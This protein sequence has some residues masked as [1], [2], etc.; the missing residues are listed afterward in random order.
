MCGSIEIKDQ[1]HVNK[2]VVQAVKNYCLI[3]ELFATLQIIHT[4]GRAPPYVL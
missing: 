3:S 1:K 4:A 2:S